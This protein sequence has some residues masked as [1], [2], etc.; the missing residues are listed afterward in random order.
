MDTE[1]SNIQEERSLTIDEVNIYTEDCGATR[2][3]CFTDC[4]IVSPILSKD[5]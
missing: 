3:N 2:L 4:L 5:L 1:K